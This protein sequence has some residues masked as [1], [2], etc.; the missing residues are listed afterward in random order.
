VPFV[1]APEDRPEAIVRCSP[2]TPPQTVAQTAARAARAAEDEK[3][4]EPTEP[5]SASPRFATPSPIRTPRHSLGSPRCRR[6]L[7]AIKSICEKPRRCVR[8]DRRD[9]RHRVDDLGCGW[10]YRPLEWPLHSPER[11]S[12]HY[13]GCRK[14]HSS[15]DKI[16][17]VVRPYDRPRAASA[18]TDR[19]VEMEFTSV[20]ISRTAER[21]RARPA[22]ACRQSIGS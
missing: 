5:H 17:I 15:T 21:K 18:N 12:R 9:R 10:L 20:S 19:G 3:V 7:S 6:V 16:E 8:P 2:P 13:F 22:L 4:A 11:R 14:R 1:I